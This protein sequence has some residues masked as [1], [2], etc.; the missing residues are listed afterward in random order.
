MMARTKR[1]SRFSLPKRAETKWVLC[2]KGCGEE[3]EIEVDSKGGICWR[4][5]QRMAGPPEALLKAK[6]KEESNKI[7][8]HR[9]WKFMK[10]YVDSEGNVFFRGE[11][12]TKLKGTKEPTVVIPKEKKSAFEKEQDRVAK[13]R[14]LA[15][16]YEKK[17]A[18]LNGKKKRG[19]K[20][21]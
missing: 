16:R 4:C 17:Q 10:E 15:A 12:Q 14:K 18:K 8:R 11:E 20:K 3:L 2:M 9:G 5:V 13:Q 7:K 6:K 1:N 19:R 21:K